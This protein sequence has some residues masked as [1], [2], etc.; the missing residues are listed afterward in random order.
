MKLPSPKLLGLVGLTLFTL[1]GGCALANK[2]PVIVSL[3]A[4]KDSLSTADSCPLRAIAYD[5][6]GG[7]L[8]YQWS[9]DGGTV[10][11][12]GS[13]VSWKTPDTPG[14][15]QI[16]VTVT[17][18]R[19]SEAEAQFSL[20]VAANTPPVIDSLSTK[21]HQINRGEFVVIECQAQ[22]DDGDELTYSW[23][24]TGGA[25]YGTG[26]VATWE[27]PLELG[28]YVITVV[29]SDGS[30]ARATGRLTLEV[31]VNHSPV[32]ESLT[33]TATVVIFGQDADITCVA[34]DPDD[35]VLSYFWSADDGELSAEGPAAIFFA[36]D[37]CGEYVT[38][39]VSVADSRGGETTKELSLRTRKPG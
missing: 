29:A 3:E 15:Y 34:T 16:S 17:D 27:A 30:G 12:E 8:S 1:L 20:E 37:T 25:F 2:V 5:P 33:S 28:S 23:S 6:D 24:A 10:S 39:T 13:A 19:G 38:I 36:P 9:A 14:S 11:G 26:P 7:E 22:D 4:E 18:D 32:I 31:T 35:D 21:R